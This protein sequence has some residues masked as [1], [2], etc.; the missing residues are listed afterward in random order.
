M[1]KRGRA[2]AADRCAGDHEETGQRA[3]LLT[4]RVSSASTRVGPPL[5]HPAVRRISGLPERAALAL[6][7]SAAYGVH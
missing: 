1:P 2:D 6:R 5:R 7:V 3:Q 4:V